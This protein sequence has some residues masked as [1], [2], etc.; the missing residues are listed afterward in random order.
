[1][2]IAPKPKVYDYS[3]LFGARLAALPFKFLT[4]VDLTHLHTYYVM[5]GGENCLAARDVLSE[6]EKR[7]ADE[8]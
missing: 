2:I 4:L 5:K 6:I 7:T 3:N 8:D 1:M